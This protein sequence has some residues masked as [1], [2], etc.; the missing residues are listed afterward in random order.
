VLLDDSRR[1]A[2]AARAA[3]VPTELHV[4][5]G[6]PHVFPLFQFLPEARAA[7]GQIAEFVLRHTGRSV[8]AAAGSNPCA[9]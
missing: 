9:S 1:A 7:L 4:W 6:M 3:G 2:A 8:P 5:P